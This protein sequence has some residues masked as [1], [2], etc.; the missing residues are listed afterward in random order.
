MGVLIVIIIG[1][2][3]VAAWEIFKIKAGIKTRRK[4]HR[5]HVGVGAS[6]GIHGPRARVYRR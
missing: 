5:K 1:L 4:R 2:A 3:A 6:I